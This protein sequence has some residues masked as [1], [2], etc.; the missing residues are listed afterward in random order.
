VRVEVEDRPGVL[1]RIAERLASH[2]IS[3]A[4]LAQHL[5]DG[6]AA[7]DVV[8]HEAPHGQVEAALAEIAALPEVDE[9]P[10]AL[11]VVSAR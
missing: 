4:R 6:H 5:V 1:A 11:P 9:H 2:E 10:E 3:V 7:L 8:T